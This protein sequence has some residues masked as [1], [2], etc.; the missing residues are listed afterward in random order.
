MPKGKKFD[1]AEKHFH[2]K[3]IRLNRQIRA[4]EDARHAAEKHDAETTAENRKLEAENEK[5]RAENVKLSELMELTPQQRN[6]LFER[7]SAEKK[8]ADTMSAMEHMGRTFLG[9]YGL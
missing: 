6:D 9:P 3:E 4:A 1:A 8:L 5:L 2:E 7:I